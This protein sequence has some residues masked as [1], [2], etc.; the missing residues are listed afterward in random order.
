MS[1]VGK[2]DPLNKVKWPIEGRQLLEGER[3]SD[4]VLWREQGIGDELI[5]LGLVPEALELSRVY[6]FI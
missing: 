4:I 6:L 5:F 3:D 1:I 2:V